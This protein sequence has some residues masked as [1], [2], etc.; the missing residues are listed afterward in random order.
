MPQS[1]DVNRQIVLNERPQGRLTDNTLRLV[2]TDVPAAGPD[3]ILVRTVYMSLDPYM[4]GRMNDA[5][6]YAEPVAIG[7]VMTAQVVGQVVTSNLAGYEEGD[8]V[9][10]MSGW[11]D[12]A[13]SDGTEV[14]NLGKDPKNSSWALGILGMPGYTA[15]A[16][17]LKI[18]EPKPGETVVVAAAAGPVGATVGQIAKLKGCRVV[19]IAG[20]AEKCAH[21][22]DTL[23]FDACIDHKAPDFAAQLKE[24]C[25]DGID[26]YFEN[27]GG[28][29]LYAVLPL[30]N[31]FARM[32]VCGIVAWYNLPGLPEGPDM[33]PAIMGTLLRMKVKMQGFIIFD[34]FPPSVYQEFRK[35]MMGWIE[36]GSIKYKEHMVDGLENAPDA[37]VQLLD[38]GNFGKMVVNVGA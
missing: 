24:A 1:A 4:R 36:D 28:K 30:L 33:A 34:S 12:Y 19:G 3:Q 35:D 7:G 25:P 9:L 13:V 6:S 5:K 18:G 32:P 20:G 15:Y 21:I 31:P 16:G 11:Q 23:G 22:V 2:T 27:V 26:V 14:I 37:F 29:V 17:L 8:Y 10:N 38:G